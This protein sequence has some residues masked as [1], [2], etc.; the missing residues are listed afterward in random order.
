ME[1]GAVPFLVWISMMV[2]PFGTIVSG[3]FAGVF[4]AIKS[5]NQPA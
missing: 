2:Q 5:D 3:L 1:W 4:G